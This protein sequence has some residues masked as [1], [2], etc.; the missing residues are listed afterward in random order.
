MLFGGQPR[1]PREARRK[2]KQQQQAEKILKNYR[3]I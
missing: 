2:A 3:S 1:I